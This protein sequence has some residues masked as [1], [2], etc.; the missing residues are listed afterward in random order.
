MSDRLYAYQRSR[1]SVSAF[2]KLQKCPAYYIL[3]THYSVVEELRSAALTNGINVHAQFESRETIHGYKVLEHEK[4]IEIEG[5]TIGNWI[6]YID[7]VCE[8]DDHDRF[9]LDI[10]TSKKPATSSW[11]KEYLL[12]LQG[13][14][15]TF[16]EQV[17]TFAIYHPT[18]EVLYMTK[19]NPAVSRT[20]LKKAYTHFMNWQSSGQKY[21]CK[22]QWSCKWCDFSG[23][24]EHL[25]T[26]PGCALPPTLELNNKQ[27]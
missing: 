1:I 22:P 3:S 20:R 2:G 27:P 26:N 7:A 24:C 18:D 9:V 11:A 12:S 21:N 10:K 14:L 4:K 5:S 25:M 8:D 17:E 15:Y 13:M 16:A 6:G 19:L 23:H